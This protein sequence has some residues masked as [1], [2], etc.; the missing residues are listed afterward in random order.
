MSRAKHRIPLKRNKTR[1]QKRP[2][3]CVSRTRIPLPKRQTA[4]QTARARRKERAEAERQE[5]EAARWFSDR[6]TLDHGAVGRCA[7]W[8]AAVEWWA[9]WQ[10]D[11]SLNHWP[12]PGVVHYR[13]QRTGRA[14]TSACRLCEH[15]TRKLMFESDLRAIRP[16]TDHPLVA[17]GAQPPDPI[18]PPTACILSYVGELELDKSLLDAFS[19]TAEDLPVGRRHLWRGGR[20]R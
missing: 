15:P 5:R 19:P 17:C 3:I 1:V 4:A 16:G 14:C 12:R 13:T 8:Q 6:S 18:E 9:D 20:G 10:A 2:G 7:G 11:R